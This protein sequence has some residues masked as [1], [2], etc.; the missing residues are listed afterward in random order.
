MCVCVCMHVLIPGHPRDGGVAQAVCHSGS[1]Q[2][3]TLGPWV[4]ICKAVGD[5]ELVYLEPP[6]LHWRVG[7]GPAAC[8][9]PRLL[10]V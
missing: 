5:G 1:L 6:S 4:P 9:S 2:A 10:G 7:L 3:I 8:R